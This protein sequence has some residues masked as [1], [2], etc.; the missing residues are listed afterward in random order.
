ML[1]VITCV[2]DEYIPALGRHASEVDRYETDVM[3]QLSYHGGDLL[4]GPLD[5]GLFS[6]CAEIL[7]LSQ[8]NLCNQDTEIVVEIIR[9]I[10]HSKWETFEKINCSI[11]TASVEHLSN[12]EHQ[13]FIF[14]ITQRIS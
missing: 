10:R 9:P 3:P 11:F 8:W 7:V 12:I 5:L 13:S 14:F 1:F 2:A 4:E 6:R